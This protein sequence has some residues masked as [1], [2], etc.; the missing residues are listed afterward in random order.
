VAPALV[1]AAVSEPASW[2]GAGAAA[3]TAAVAASFTI[4]I[5]TE[6]VTDV[7]PAEPI[8]AVVVTASAEVA[9]SDRSRAPVSAAP[10]PTSAVTARLTMLRATEAP[11]TTEPPVLVELLDAVGRPEVVTWAVSAA[12]IVTSPPPAATLA[13][14]LI[15]AVVVSWTMSMASEPATPIFAPPLPEAATAAKR[16][17]GLAVPV[18]VARTV[19]PRAVICAPWP[20]TA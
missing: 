14:G 11:M 3:P 13:E 17:A 20:M 9:D 8:D 4:A 7:P 19:T 12:A 5:A 1:A 10:S 15:R 2:S 16:S 18:L 6:G